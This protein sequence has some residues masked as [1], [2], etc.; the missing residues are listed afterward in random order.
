MEPLSLL[1]LHLLSF[2]VSTVNLKW[3]SSQLLPTCTSYRQR[4]RS[5]VAPHIIGRHPHLFPLPHYVF[6]RSLP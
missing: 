1:F 5:A 6:L 4:T 2:S 3:P